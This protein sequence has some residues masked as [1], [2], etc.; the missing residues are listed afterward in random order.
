MK[1][2]KSVLVVPL[3]CLAVIGC[4]NDD[5]ANRGAGAVA[6][7]EL[8]KQTASSEFFAEAASSASTATSEAR[9]EQSA[10][11]DT[12]KPEVN[13][14]APVA[15]AAVLSGV[16]ERSDSKRNLAVLAV[17]EE[18]ANLVKTGDR[19]AEQW[20]VASIELSKV[21]LVSH[22]GH[23][24]SVLLGSH[25]KGDDVAVSSPPPAPP[26]PRPDQFMIEQA[27]REFNSP[28]ND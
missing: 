1:T 22:T 15:P 7:V 13:S 27:E 14:V 9:R 19:I 18:S 21:V 8:Q 3:V 11:D 28:E 12:L 10:F 25:V 4:S 6:R 20:T 23:T 2:S 16:V 26:P 5:V 17:G 24:H